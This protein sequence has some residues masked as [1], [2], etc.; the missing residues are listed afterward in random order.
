MDCLWNTEFQTH[1]RHTPPTGLVAGREAV[2]E[3]VMLQVSVCLMVFFSP[4]ENSPCTP[5][6]ASPTASALLLWGGWRWESRKQVWAISLF[7]Y[8]GCRTWAGGEKEW[9]LFRK[10]KYH[11]HKEGGLILVLFSWLGSI[12]H[13]PGL[14]PEREPWFKK[15]KWVR[16]IIHF[17]LTGS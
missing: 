4:T 10:V 3:V 16:R 11:P 1:F 7:L 12:Q 14:S 8:Q 6:S 15:M 2:K 5:P 13:L 17:H 9:L